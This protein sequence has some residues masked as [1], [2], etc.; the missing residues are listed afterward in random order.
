MGIDVY[1]QWDGMNEAEKSAQYTGFSVQ[2][3]HVG[4]LREAYHGEPYATRVLVPEAFADN[5]P[6]EGA[7]ISAE[8]MRDRLP[9]VI[10]AAKQREMTVYKARSIK[11][12]DPVVQAFVKFVELAE[13]KEKETGKAC[14]V[15]ASY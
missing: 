8:T 10:G 1:L 9:D 13:T 3:G 12:T 15:V 5:A 6:E 14:R 7:A 11:E 4:Y 2:S